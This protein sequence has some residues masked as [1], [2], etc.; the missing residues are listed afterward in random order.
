MLVNLKLTQ[1]QIQTLKRQGEDFKAWITTDKGKK[2]NQ[3]HRE[4]ERYFKEQLSS[5]RLKKI[6]ESELAEKK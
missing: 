3:E 4:H 5:E 6:T 1:E 2:D